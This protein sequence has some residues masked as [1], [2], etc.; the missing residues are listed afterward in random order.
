MDQLSVEQFKTALPKEV[1]KSVNQELLDSINEK[2]AD[3]DMYEIYRENLLS[4]AHIMREGKFK[5]SGYIDAV[6]YVSQK[7]MG[8]TNIDSFSITFPEKIQRWNDEEVSSKDIAS[9]VTAYNKSKMVTL[10]TEQTLTPFWV[11]NQDVYQKAIN[12]QAELM[13]SARSE[14]V[15]SDAA[16]SLL[17]HLKPP[18]VKKVELDIGAKSDGSIEA[19][20]ETTRALVEQQRAALKAGVV[21]A[22]ELAHKEILVQGEVVDE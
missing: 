15:R 7:M 16:N 22:Q 6:K 19:L 14:K 18:E 2:L 4:Y 1:R 12:T 3:P 10:I 11:M 17:S 9:Y 21:N 8:K 20:R 5:L 13:V